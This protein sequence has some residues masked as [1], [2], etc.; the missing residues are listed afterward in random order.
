MTRVNHT[1]RIPVTKLPIN[2]IHHIPHLGT[3]PKSI[4][5]IRIPL[6]HNPQPG[7]TTTKLRH[8]INQRLKPTPRLQHTLI[9]HHLRPTLRLRRRLRKT[10][11]HSRNQHMRPLH[12][13]RIPPLAPRSKKTAAHRLRHKNLSTKNAIDTPRQSMTQTPLQLMTSTHHSDIPSPR[14]LPRQQHSKCITITMHMHHRPTSLMT[15]ITRQLQRRI[16]IKHPPQR[17]MTHINPRIAKPAVDHLRIARI[18][19]HR[20]PPVTEMATH[21]Q[22]MTPRIAPPVSAD[23]MDQPRPTPHITI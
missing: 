9:K 2:Q 12:R 16:H 7:L 20:P 4:D 19:R 13:K 1:P 22:R 14:K 21:I 11:I 8:S 15:Q 17:T 3:P 23:D 5:I 6:T 10:N 18:R